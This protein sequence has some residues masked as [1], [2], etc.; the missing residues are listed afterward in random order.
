MDSLQPITLEGEHVQLLPLGL[1]HHAQL[2]Q[3]GLD[4]D[5]WRFTTNQI[6]T[7]ADM[8]EYIQS[9]LVEQSSGTCLPF[10]IV[11]KDSG[12]VV[13]SSRYHSFD[14][15]NRRIVIGYT[16]I[17]RDWQRTAVNTEAKYLMLKYAFEELACV[18]V[19]FIVNAVNEKSRRALHRIGARHE[20]MMRNYVIGKAKE[21]C[22]VALFSILNTE[23]PHIKTNLELKLI[24]TRSRLNSQVESSYD[25]VAADY[26]KEFGEELTRKPFDRKMLEWLIEKVNKLGPICD[27]GCGPGQVAKYLHSC[28]AETFGVDLSEEMAKHAKLISPELRFEQGNMLALKKIAD[29]SLGGVAAFYSL[30]H[31]QRESMVDVLS[32]F[33]R[34][35]RPGGVVLTANH[36]GTGVVHR[37]EWFSKPVSLEFLFFET[38]EMKNYVIRSGLQLEEVIER[39]P[40]PGFEYPSRRAYTFAR[41]Q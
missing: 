17:G 20:G 5:L 21:P 40:Y 8:H 19:Q 29:D 35:L 3:I 6:L 24:Q 34:V 13:G 7:D 33:K 15:I 9:A 37:E 25:S 1:N 32:E 27:M 4:Q 36:I 10:V 16:W 14:M 30:V 41:K 12:K 11:E 26:A 38:E 2:C 31:I 39:D 18:R 23:W 28:N 22:D